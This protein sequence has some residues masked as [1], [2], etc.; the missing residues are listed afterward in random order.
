[1]NITANSSSGD[2][3]NEDNSNKGSSSHSEQSNH[4]NQESSQE[5]QVVIEIRSAGTQRIEKMTLMPG[6]DVSIGRAWDNHVIV[7]DKYIDPTHLVLSVDET[8]TLFVRDASTKN[9]SRLGKQIITEAIAYSANEDIRIGDTRLRLH[10]G[11]TMVSPALPLDFSHTFK[12]KFGSKLAIISI[13]LLTLLIYYFS[14]SLTEITELTMKN[15]LGAFATFGVVAFL[16]SLMGGFIG[17]LFRHEMNF[18]AHWVLVCFSVVGSIIL[19]LLA[20]ILNFN[21]GGSTVSTLFEYAVWAVFILFFVYGALSFSTRIGKPK[22]MIISVLLAIT[23]TLFVLSNLLLK[24]ERGLW[25]RSANSDFSTM[26]PVFK[27]IGSASYEKH[28]ASVDDL[29]SEL[30]KELENSLNKK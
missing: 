18:S 9:G 17:K 23:P 28:Q 15:I 8:G 27:V 1:M 14:L 21:L 26:A 11:D 4:S 6:T 5:I 3:S 30:D 29:F 22:K 19:F 25:S 24:D 20:D 13:T 10:R 12:R 16:W 7:N 2:G